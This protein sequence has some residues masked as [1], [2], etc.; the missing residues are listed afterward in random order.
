MA[1]RPDAWL[2]R[3][4]GQPLVDKAVEECARDYGGKVTGDPWTFTRTDP[5]GDRSRLPASFV[6][7]ENDPDR[8]WHAYARV[9][10]WLEVSKAGMDRLYG[11]Q[12]NEAS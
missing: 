4:E 5:R 6:L 8:W 10:G 11:R 2:L 9:H 7:V 12:A 3:G 1:P